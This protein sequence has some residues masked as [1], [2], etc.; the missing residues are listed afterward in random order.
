[1]SEK[2]L[3][4]AISLRYAEMKPEERVTEVRMLSGRSAEDADFIRQ[5]FP[6][7]YE[8]AF[9]RRRRVAGGCSESS[10]PTSLTAKPR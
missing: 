7:L 6:Q 5:N 8:E 9:P 4:H 10:L 1:M 3:I 2:H